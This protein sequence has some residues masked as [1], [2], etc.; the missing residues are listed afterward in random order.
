MLRNFRF[1]KLIFFTLI[2]TLTLS[3]AALA[4]F[5]KQNCARQKLGWSFYCDQQKSESNKEYNEQLSSQSQGEVAT[6]EVERLKK[7]HDILLNTALIF[8]TEEN[9]KKYLAFN[10]ENLD[11]SSY[12]A[13][14]A[15]RVIWQTPELNYN[16][17]R[18]VNS[19]GKR[20]WIDE[21]N[22][23]Q[24]ETAL[25]L[26]SRYGIFFFYRGDC[27]YCHAYSPVL[28]TFSD[29]YNLKIKGVSLDGKVLSEFPDSIIDS[30][31]ASQLGINAVPATVL[32][33]KE[34]QEIIPVGYGALAQDE[35]LR[36]IYTLTK[37]KPGEEL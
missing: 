2:M 8:P 6:Q 28:K 24:K 4:S 37:I 14:S 35:L 25:S 5:Y 33:D 36:Q 30:G 26:S 27:P 18:P 16:L 7:Q 10:L 31:Q 21:Q 13:E 20:T 23:K 15:E 34:T 11:R 32:F 12:F 3:K 1:Y 22:K 29:T 9:I 17:K 19:V